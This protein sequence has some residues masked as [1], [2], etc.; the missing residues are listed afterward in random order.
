MP[1]AGVILP[2]DPDT[3]PVLPL[4]AQGIVPRATRYHEA[5]S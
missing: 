4:T 5:E 3:S 1:W 2:C